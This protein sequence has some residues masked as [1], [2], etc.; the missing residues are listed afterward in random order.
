MRTVNTTRFVSSASAVRRI[1]TPSGL[2]PGS[3]FLALACLV[4]LSGGVGCAKKGTA[5]EAKGEVAAPAGGEEKAGER[6]EEATPTVSVA[7]LHR[8]AVEKTLPLTGTL[9]AP[10][11]Q[12]SSVNAPVAG[13]LDT[14]AA[15]PGQRVE[16][17]QIIAHLST[18]LLLGQVQQAEATVAQTSV[19]VEQARANAAGQEAQSQSAVLQ[20]QA[21]VSVAKATL[22]GARATLAGSDASLTNA[23]QSL[24]R[25]R[26]LFAEGL[27]A[28][29]DVEA[30]Q[31]A[32]RAAS[33]Q[34]ATQ[35]QIIASQRG[36]VR[37]QEL[38]VAV[39]RATGLQIIVKRKD[40]AVAGAQLRSARGALTTAQ[41][42]FGLYTV[43]APIS[44]VV[45]TVGAALG[46]NVDT[47][48][49]LVTITNLD[50][51]SLQISVQSGSASGVHVGQRVTFSVDALPGR[52]FGAVIYSV[53]A[54][55]DPASNTVTAVAFVDN[56]R[57]QLKD[58]QFVRVQLVEGRRENALLAPRAAV[59]FTPGT[60][61]ASKTPTGNAGIA[62]KV[63]V[64]GSDGAAH[65]TPVTV[66][67]RAGDSI[68]IL[69]GLKDG[70]K[71]V[72]TG[73][74]GLPDGAKV[75]IAGPDKDAKGKGEAAD[76]SDA[77]TDKSGATPKGGGKSGG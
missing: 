52:R 70:D 35:V 10:R 4:A 20:A 42:Q 14:F 17:G 45:T 11:D 57:H 33:A 55:V 66:G 15:R 34:R 37:T 12:Q 65:Q 21:A 30:A 71:V 26:T 25:T 67:F 13:L 46:E 38:A 24:A 44:G 60:D 63:V 58:A 59:L 68:E 76:K 41:S 5:A 56:T 53:G 51:L 32:V 2:M 69:S 54:Q 9:A 29:K 22:A 39:A 23:K 3:P 47:T 18:R 1:G 31:L 8:G 36:T 6:K 50:R 61:D 28:Q 19:Q 72:V 40:I 27:V 73:A 48:T 74:Y 75:E 43:R 62:A 7:P 64:V 16:R 77:A 49:K